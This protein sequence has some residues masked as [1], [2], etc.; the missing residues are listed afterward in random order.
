MSH[1]S[2]EIENWKKVDAT[3]EFDLNLLKR[4][5]YQGLKIDAI[6]YYFYVKERF[7]FPN[8]RY[9]DF[10]Q[11][12][13]E[14]TVLTANDWCYLFQSDSNLIIVCGDDLINIVV[15]S[16]NDPPVKLNCD[17]FCENLNQILEK[18]NLRHLDSSR[19]NLYLNYSLLLNNL[20]YEYKSKISQKL[21]ALPPTFSVQL[22]EMDSEDPLIKYKQI[23]YA[24][25][26]W[27]NGMET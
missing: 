3:I 6:K 25:D 11:F 18:Q 22:D 20:I 27:K 14:K 24:R 12:F 17:I 16:I 7:G 10:A 8:V 13:P 4:V 26:Y 21:P 9:A 2:L 15:L 5:N 23:E 1:P 19:F